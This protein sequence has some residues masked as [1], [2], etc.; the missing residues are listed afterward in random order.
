MIDRL[1]ILALLVAA[2]LPAAAQPAPSER[3]YSVT[4]F[5]RIR[6]DGPY[7]V[8]LQTNV[9]PYAR[10]SGSAASLDGVSVDVEGRTL[11]VRAGSGSWGGYTGE[12]RGPVTI[13]LGTHELGTA[14][15]NGPGALTIDRVKGLSFDLNIQGSGSAQ[16][17]N[18]EVDQMK[19]GISGA[20]S[21]RLAGS[22]KKLIA[23]IRGTSAFEADGL[24]VTDAVIG[25]E[26]PVIIHATVTNS[27]KV[28][29]LGVASVTLG[30]NPACTVKAQ[31]SAVVTGCK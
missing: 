14:W 31:G 24:T 12:A 30:G 10:A 21:T 15:I 4:S 26:G 25:A 19:V 22:A 20:G 6:I 5:D 3:N 11:I 16:I 9:A 18:A 27:A 29:A 8:H 13:E 23:I 7:Q 17:D 1:P 2:S 28:D